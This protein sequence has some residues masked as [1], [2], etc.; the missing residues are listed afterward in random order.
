MD[1][2]SPEVLLFLS[3]ACSNLLFSRSS[4]LYNSTFLFCYISYKT[5]RSMKYFVFN[6]TQRDIVLFYAS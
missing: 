1:S 3:I 4:I 2:F 5:V 6:I